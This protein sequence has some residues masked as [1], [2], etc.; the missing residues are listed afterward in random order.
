MVEAIPMYSK[1][2]ERGW[3][4]KNVMLAY[5]GV[6]GIVGDMFLKNRGVLGMVGDVFLKK[7]DRY[8]VI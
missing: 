4:K 6:L 1:H 2:L 8:Y 7:C 3:N 5:K